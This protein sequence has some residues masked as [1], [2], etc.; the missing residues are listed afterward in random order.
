MKQSSS[1]IA[2]K[3]NETIDIVDMDA[4]ELSIPG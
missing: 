3:R 1:K 4:R 2:F